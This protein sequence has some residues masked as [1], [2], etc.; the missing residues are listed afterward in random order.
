MTM[1][2]A[3]ETAT[4]AVHKSRHATFG[5][6][7]TLALLLILGGSLGLLAS[8]V[9]TH[10]K[11]ELLA[12]PDYV[13][14]CSINPVLSCN[15]IMKSWQASTFGF[16]NPFIGWAAFPAV[17]AIGAGLLAGARYRRWH[18]L[19]LQA[20]TVFGI[21]LIT[22]LQYSSLYAIGALCL[23][24][25]LVWAVTI[26]IFWYTTVHNIQHGLIPAPDRVR[27]TVA[28]FHWAVPVL[29]IGIIALL[30]LTRWGSALWA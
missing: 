8:A 4:P 27:C 23:W 29:W 21:G 20:G 6:S 13:S 5:A 17:I 16:P 7:R 19:G 10:D 22:W 1:P 30:I 15:N 28:E 9:L 11:M 2:A 12:N 3:R 26:L 14:A 18:W 24:C 25:T